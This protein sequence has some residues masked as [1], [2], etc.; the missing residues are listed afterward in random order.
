MMLTRALA[1]IHG[2]DER[3]PVAV[4]EQA[5]AIMP[6]IVRHVCR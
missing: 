1:T 3:V 2:H 5:V 4:F 6:D